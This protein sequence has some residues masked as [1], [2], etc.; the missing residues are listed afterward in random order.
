MH[1]KT[2]KNII[3]NSMI[4]TLTFV[5]FVLSIIISLWLNSFW[6][7][8]PYYTTILIRV[9]AYALLITIAAPLFE[10][11][12]RVCGGSEKKGWYIDGLKKHLH[13]ILF[14]GA[15]LAVLVY[16]TVEIISS[17]NLP[18]LELI[19]LLFLTALIAEGKMTKGFVNSFKIG[20]KYFY[21]LIPRIVF[22]FI[23]V[24]FMSMITNPTRS[25]P[26]PKYRGYIYLKGLLTGLSHGSIPER[27]LVFLVFVLPWL[28]L[29]YTAA[30]IFTYSMNLYL[31][32]KRKR[33]DIEKTNI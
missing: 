5:I 10:Y 33:I 11:I 23:L 17:D 14:S 28:L 6:A 16:V 18:M 27:I 7:D 15:V 13:K 30:Y 32:E 29:I 3:E 20:K 19:S 4:L 22:I 31:Y 24:L 8:Y 25:Y 1:K 26:Y 21:K 2:F 12:Y 9:I